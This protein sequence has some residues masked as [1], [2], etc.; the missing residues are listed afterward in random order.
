[1]RSPTCDAAVMFVGSLFGPELRWSK[2]G[3]TVP[4][5]SI[6][7]MHD[8]GREYSELSLNWSRARRL[9]TADRLTGFDI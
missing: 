6:N 7:S 2:D 5:A 4:H 9:P 1:M 3:H 8:L